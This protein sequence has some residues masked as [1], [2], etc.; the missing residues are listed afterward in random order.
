MPRGGLI[1]AILLKTLS[2]TIWL[3]IMIAIIVGSLRPYRI[4][5]N[6]DNVKVRNKAPY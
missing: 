4:T 3:V 1:L 6:E 2:F 5:E